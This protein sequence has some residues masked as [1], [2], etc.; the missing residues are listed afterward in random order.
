MW[1]LGQ[2]LRTGNLKRNSNIY[3]RIRLLSATQ[4]FQV[5]PPHGTRGG[6]FLSRPVVYMA[7]VGTEIDI[8]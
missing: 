2:A 1:I 7:L 5:L 6:F 4:H 3:E 8:K